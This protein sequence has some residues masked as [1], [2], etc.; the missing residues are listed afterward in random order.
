MSGLMSNSGI[1]RSSSSVYTE[2][3]KL[4][5]DI[6]SEPLSII[7]NNSFTNSVCPDEWRCANVIA[8]FKK[9]DHKYKSQ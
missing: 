2:L 1:T 7:Y 9:G 3:S 4:V 8:L 6:L 5:N